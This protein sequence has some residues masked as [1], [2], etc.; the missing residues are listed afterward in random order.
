MRL[1]SGD[2]IALKLANGRDTFLP[3]SELAQWVLAELEAQARHTHSYCDIENTPAIPPAVQFVRQ[4]TDALGVL[5]WT[6][7]VAYADGVVPVIGC[8][9]EGCD[10]A[11]W[12]TQIIAIDNK[13][14]AVRLTKMSAVVF[15][16]LA[17]PQA[18]VHLT[19][20]AP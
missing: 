13:G 19:A 18:Y 9:V 14:A 12:S 6:F 1:N 3:V 20:I 7:P 2:R 16:P 11:V 5:T 17:D 10:E 4:Q 8:A 15:G